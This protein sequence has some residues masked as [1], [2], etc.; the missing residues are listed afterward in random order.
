MTL[1][2][3]VASA[4]L[5]LKDQHVGIVNWGPGITIHT[6]VARNATAIERDRSPTNVI[7]RLVLAGVYLV[8]KERIAIDA[9]MDTI[10]SQI[11]DHVIVIPQELGQISVM[12]MA[13]VNVI[14]V[15]RVFASN[16]WKDESVQPAKQ[17]HL[18]YLK[19]KK[20]MDVRIVFVL[21][22]LTSAENYKIMYGLNWVT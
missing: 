4:Q 17:V 21:D 13:F 12:K 2:L 3:A 20:F 18:V 5:I 7:L 16:T 14:S 15:A 10:I 1:T 19:M 8:L 11:V 22:E 6:E 9:R